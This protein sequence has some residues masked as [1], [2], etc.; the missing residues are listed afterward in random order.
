[1]GCLTDLRMFLTSGLSRG[2]SCAKPV[3]TTWKIREDK[4]PQQLQENTYQG[5]IFIII[6]VKGYSCERGNRALEIVFESR[7]F[8]GL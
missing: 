5:M 3:F 6:R 7:P 4:I 8:L 2:C 1:M